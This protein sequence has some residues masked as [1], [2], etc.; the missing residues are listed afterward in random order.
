MREAVCLLFGDSR[1]GAAPLSI[2]PNSAMS[3]PLNNLSG[4]IT[5]HRAEITSTIDKVVASGWFISGPEVKKFE[6]AFSTYLGAKHCIGVGNGTDAL[7]L[8]LRAAGVK[9]GDLVATVANAGAYATTAIL[10][11]G[12]SPFFLDVSPE[13]S[14]TSVGE[15]EKAIQSG[16][17]AVV[18]T[19]LY[20]LAVPDISE[21]ARRCDKKGVFLLE[22]CAQA[23]GARI[24]HKCAGTFGN[25]AA[26]SFYPTKNLGALGDGGAVIANDPDLAA[27]VAS[28]RQYGWS[29]KYRIELAGARN[30]RLDEIQAALLRFFLPQLDTQN[31]RRRQIAEQYSKGIQHPSVWTPQHTGENYVAHLYVIQSAQR[32]SLKVHLNTRQIGSDIHYP[33]PDYRQPVFGK[34]FHGVTLANTEFLAK[35]ILTLPCYPE[36]TDSEVN[37]VISAVNEWTP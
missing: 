17:K 12:A 16:V 3:V 28:L 19:H 34:Q 24:N 36:M 7:E 6:E 11:I 32:D 25:A 27:R 30:S 29:S 22:D 9:R 10:A 20:G 2:T 4:R 37:Q 5:N 35:N 14:V 21:I 18:C 8:A 1:S 23:H 31:Q 26:F 33:V 15:V 13:T